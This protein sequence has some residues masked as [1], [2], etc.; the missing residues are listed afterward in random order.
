[1][2][3]FRILNKTGMGKDTQI[4]FVNQDGMETE[5]SGALTDVKIHFG[6]DDLCRAEIT[7]ESIVDLDA[8]VHAKLIIKNKEE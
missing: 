7:M 8:D 2:K 6:I 5:I 3:K 1:M 4:F